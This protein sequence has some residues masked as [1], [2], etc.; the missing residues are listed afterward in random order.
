MSIEEKKTRIQNICNDKNLSVN[1][2]IDAILAIHRE[3]EEDTTDSYQVGCTAYES[4]RQILL[5]E[6][7]ENYYDYDLLMCDCLLAEAYWHVQKSWL[8]AP[9]AQEVYYILLSFDTTDA[10]V[11]QTVI[12]IL[13]RICYV[14][15]GTGHSRLLMKLYAMQYRFEQKKVEPDNDE[16]RSVA[17]D[18]ISLVSLTG[19]TA[20]YK[21]LEAGITLLL[22]QKEVD[23]LMRNPKVGHL[24]VDP[25][26]YTESW[27]KIIDDVEAEIDS[28]LEHEPRGMGFCFHYWSV[29]KNLLSEKYGIEWRSPALMNPG[30]MFD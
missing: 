18:L 6:N 10:N 20:Y 8:V 2:K 19:Y 30:V 17:A 7:D 12:Q 15:K 23:E 9:L 1:E 16:L 27:E 21:P 24:K 22:G 14:L 11:L 3:V 25:V 13:D 29:K 28:M 4:I 26:E 5:D